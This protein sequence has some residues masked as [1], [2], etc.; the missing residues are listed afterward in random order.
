MLKVQYSAWMQDGPKEFTP[1]ENRVRDNCPSK[2]SGDNISMA[3][4]STQ[5]PSAQASM[6]GDVWNEI[7]LQVD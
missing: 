3:E 4:I 2:E 1:G 7:R 6:N 5:A